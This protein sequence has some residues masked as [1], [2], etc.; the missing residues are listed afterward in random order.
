M[1]LFGDF[2]FQFLCIFF[3]LGRFLL[4]DILLNVYTVLPSTENYLLIG[5]IDFICSELSVLIFLCN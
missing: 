2:L 4:L 5:S 1:L 3:F